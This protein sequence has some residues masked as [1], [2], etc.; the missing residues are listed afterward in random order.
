MGF[1]HNTVAQVTLIDLHI[2]AEKY[3]LTRHTGNR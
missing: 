2:D 3:L 1:F